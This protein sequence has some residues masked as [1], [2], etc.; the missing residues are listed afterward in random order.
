[1]V[2]NRCRDEGTGRARVN[3]RAVDEN[4]GERVVAALGV[5]AALELL[6]VLERPDA[7]RAGLIGRLHVRADAAWLAD[8]LI[9]LEDEV[10]EIARL[11]FVDSLRDRLEAG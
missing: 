8:L 2:P 3:F 5:P 1:M 10:G 11:R 6:E 7:E 9:D 4:V